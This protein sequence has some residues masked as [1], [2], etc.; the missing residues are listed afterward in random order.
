MATTSTL[1]QMAPAVAYRLQD[2]N[3][4][5]WNLSFENYAALAEGISELLLIVGRPTVIFNQPVTI[6]SN[7][8]FQDMPPGLLVVTDIR[9][10]VSR[11]R[12]TTLRSLDYLCPS[13]T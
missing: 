4:I 13:W 8:C 1:A 5:F 11:L 6:Q 2:P 7:V 9:S 3:S 12:K 10:Q